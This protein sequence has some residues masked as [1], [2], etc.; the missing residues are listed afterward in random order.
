[1]AQQLAFLNP[2]LPDNLCRRWL[3]RDQRAVISSTQYVIY[4]D[5][6]IG[7][8]KKSSAIEDRHAA[9]CCLT[10]D[11]QTPAR[12]QNRWQMGK[13]QTRQCVPGAERNREVLA[14]D[15]K[16]REFDGRLDSHH[17]AVRPILTDYPG[18]NFIEARKAL[19]GCRFCPVAHHTLDQPPLVLAARRHIGMW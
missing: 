6:V 7:Q 14:S 13:E 15:D 9:K 17:E 5:A 11:D 4:S 3:S 10:L 1:L 8:R 12:R 2:T 19:S 16:V 18:I